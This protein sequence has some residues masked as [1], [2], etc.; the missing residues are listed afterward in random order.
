MSNIK[1]FIVTT[2]IPEG[3]TV[4]GMKEYIKEAISAWKGG[5][6]PEDPI[7]DLNREKIKVEFELNTPRGNFILQGVSLPIVI[8]ESFMTPHWEELFNF[9]PMYAK[10]AD[11]E[12]LSFSGYTCRISKELEIKKCRKGRTSEDWM[13][14]MLSH[15]G[16]SYYENK[17]LEFDELVK[18]NCGVTSG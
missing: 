14:R 8:D 15:F 16:I 7:F 11:G 12:I 6:P 10:Y 18:K 2:E 17:C 3:A 5:L 9:Y 13:S 1:K 4:T